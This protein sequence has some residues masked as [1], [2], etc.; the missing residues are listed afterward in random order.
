MTNDF[1]RPGKTRGALDP[2]QITLL[3]SV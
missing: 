3:V 1:A 2:F